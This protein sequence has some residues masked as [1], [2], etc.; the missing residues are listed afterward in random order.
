[1]VTLHWNSELH[2]EF[3][4][5]K[6]L[7]SIIIQKKF[8]NQCILDNIL[9]KANIGHTSIGLYLWGVGVR[10][11][12]LHGN[13][14]SKF[15]CWP[16]LLLSQSDVQPDEPSQ[17]EGAEGPRRHDHGQRFAWISHKCT[18]SIHVTN[19]HRCS[20][21]RFVLYFDRNIE[22]VLFITTVKSHSFMCLIVILFIPGLKFFL[23]CTVP[24][25]P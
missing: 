21:F 18:Y 5:L 10:Q 15:T 20:A 24:P 6:L 11:S 9:T 13:V 4:N 7:I 22:C 8:P 19:W 1:M 17:T 2:W 3:A 25:P 16:F 12:S 23:F 14:C